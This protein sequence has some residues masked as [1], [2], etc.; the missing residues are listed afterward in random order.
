M[1]PFLWRR[2]FTLGSSVSRGINQSSAYCSVTGGA[3][4]NRAHLQ[5]RKRS[6]TS[7]GGGE[8]Q[9]QIASV[10]SRDNI[11]TAA[12]VNELFIFYSLLL[13]P[14]FSVTCIGDI[15]VHLS[16]CHL[17]TC[18]LNGCLTAK[19]QFFMLLAEE[20]TQMIITDLTWLKK[21]VNITCFQIY[22]IITRFACSRSALNG[23]FQ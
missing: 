14:A 23:D 15:F 20:M 4:E 5:G 11:L 9:W 16:T 19:G 21:V 13:T 8:G 1:T 6:W 22:G 2:Q 18:Y 17:S 12:S 7:Q 3:L 10:T